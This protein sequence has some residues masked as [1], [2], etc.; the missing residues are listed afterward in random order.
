MTT[1]SRGLHVVAPIRR[2]LDY[3][4]V[5]VMAKSLAAA[6]VDEAPDALT[7]EFMK[8]KR[9]GR[10]FVDTLRNRKA[11]TSVAPWAVR[12][13]AGAPVAMPLR[14]DELSEDVGPRAWTLRDIAER[15]RAGD[16]W[17][18][19]SEAAASPRS[20][21]KRLADAA[22]VTVPPIRATPQASAAAKDRAISS[23]I[24]GAIVLSEVG[25][26]CFCSRWR[27]SLSATKARG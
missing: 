25:T 9:A 5:L 2:E 1:G 26:S 8:E 14:E 6:L 19:F 27:T 3:P 24:R 22:A 10:V 11:H 20:A 18:G 4:D 15:L 16:P 17:D 13:K 7:T 21:A 12:A 23:T